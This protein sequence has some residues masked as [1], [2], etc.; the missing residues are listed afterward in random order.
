MFSYVDKSVRVHLESQGK[1]KTID[2]EGNLVASED[3]TACISLLGPV[4]IPRLFG[5][6]EEVVLDWYCFVR[7]T[8]LSAVVNAGIAVG[9]GEGEAFRG[10][11]NSTMS[12][13]SVFAFPGF[14]SSREPL[15][16]LH[17]CCLTGDIFGSMR[18]DCGPQLEGAFEQIKKN[19]SGAVVYMSGHEGRG[20]GL[21]AK[22]ATYLLQDTGQNTYE[23]NTS[24]G[25][26]E[27]SRDFGDAAIILKYL[28]NDRSVRLLSNNPEKRRQ[29]EENGLVVSASVPIVVGLNKYNKRYLKAKSDK[30]HLFNTTF[31]AED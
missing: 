31:S 27:D 26:P 13:N 10:L 30:G 8:E 19:G 4:P 25:L 16:R 6:I 17:S 9:A 15:I 29:L 23:A 7:R 18:C 20:I 1:L 5:G 28:L 12:V 14:L 3:E 2:N 21:W 11:I 22:A 24:L